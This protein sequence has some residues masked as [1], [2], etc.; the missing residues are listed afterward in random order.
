MAERVG[1]YLVFGP[2]ASG[3]MATVHLARLVGPLGFRRT[4]AAKKLRRELVNAEMALA[5]VDEARLGARVQH[6]NVVQVLDVVNEGEQPIV[7]MEHVLGASLSRLLR[8]AEQAGVAVEVPIARA[9]GADMLTGLHA[10]HAATDEAGKPLGIVHRDVSPQNVLVGVDGIARVADF[11]VAKA[12]G[13]A[14]FTRDGQV[15]GKLAYMSPEQM[16]GEAVDARTDV[17]AAG[18]VIW[19]MLTGTR[20][21]VG[22]DDKQTIGRV[23]VA[24]VPPPSH[25]RPELAPGLDAILARALDRDPSTRFA[26]ARAFAEALRASGPS[27]TPEAVGAWVERLCGGELEERRHAIAAVESGNDDAPSRDRLV[28]PADGAERTLSLD[29]AAEQG[30][31]LPATPVRAAPARG[32]RTWWLVA[33]LVA[34]AAASVA[35]VLLR[36]APAPDG[37]ATAGA[38]VEASA[39]L[40]P[41]ASVAATAASAPTTELLPAPTSAAASAPA[42]TSAT[43]TTAAVPAQSKKPPS[44]PPA[45]ADCQPPWILDEHGRKRYR[46]E[47]LR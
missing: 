8:T 11:G 43:S 28:A 35:A 5:L 46:R 25:R 17:F 29:A 23:L 24:E 14:Q 22:E 21:F 47:C 44:R 10:A 3:G 41:A 1:R 45:A 2:F 7:F 40:T 18:I 6:P 15:K 16:R 13:R 42:P 31:S 26:T 36:T 20:L 33:G 37:A 4:L 32:R 12:L 34:A 30:H 38:A 27:A 39:P 9:I 19:E